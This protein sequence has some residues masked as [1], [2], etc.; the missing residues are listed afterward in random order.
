MFKRL[1]SQL[2]ALVL[3]VVIG[4]TGCS[5]SP[6]GLVGDYRQDT[7]AVLNSMKSVLELPDDSPRQTSSAGFSSSKYQ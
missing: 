5:A 3:V 2:F 1:W 4:L 7:L 6:G